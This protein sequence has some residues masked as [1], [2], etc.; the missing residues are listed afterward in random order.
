MLG[1]FLEVSIHC[2]DVLGSL[3]FYEALG[4][5]QAPVGEAWKHP[6]AVV[7]DGRLHLGLHAY[8]FD[9]PALTWAQPDLRRHVP[10]LEAAGIEFEFL[11]LGEESFNELG[12]LSPE[13]TM[14]TLLEARTYSPVARRGHET[15]LLDWFEE[16]LLPCSSTAASTAFWERLGFV[17]VEESDEPVPHVGL[18]SDSFNVALTSHAAITEPLLVFK[19]RGLAARRERLAAAGIEPSRLPRALQA[20]DRLLLRSPEGTGLLIVADD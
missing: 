17:A 3:R 8:E 4:F 2:P 18:T 5:T 14:I 13:G 20:R 6:Y 1:R 16:I 15:S 7:T 19:A 11:K 12:F 9:S 10:A